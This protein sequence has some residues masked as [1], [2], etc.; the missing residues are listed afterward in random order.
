M[1]THAILFL[2][3]FTTH[4]YSQETKINEDSLQVNDSLQLLELSSKVQ[5]LTL[6]VQ[7]MKLQKIVMLN[8]LNSKGKSDSIRKIQQKSQIDSLRL[9]TK[10]VPLVIEGDTLFLLYAQKGGMRPTER[11]ES[12]QNHIISLGKKLIFN[13]DSIYA[14][15]S[16]L[17]TDIMSQD[18]II[19]SITDQDAL[20]QNCT[21]EELVN[22]YI[23]IISQCITQLHAQYGLQKKMINILLVIA[24][25]VGLIF[26]IY[27]TLKIFRILR[28]Y[29][30]KYTRKRLKP[31]AIKDYELLNIRKLEYILAG[32]VSI[33]KYMIILVEVILALSMLF[34]IFPETEDYAYLLLSY[35]WNPT[36]EI[37]LSCIRFIPDLFKIVLI[38]ILF[39]YVIKGIRY[40]AG[41]IANE[42]LK[43]TG[44]YPDWAIPTYSILRFMLY[45]FMLVMIWPLL[46]NSGSPVFQGVSVFLGL[47]IS[48]GSTSVIGNLM[49][50]FVITYMRPFRIGDQIKLND[51]VGK[52]I[53]K[54]PF[55][56]RIETP[57]KE[58]ITIPNSFVLSSHTINYSTS[59]RKSGVII[60]SDITVGYD[61]D[62]VKVEELL[63]K[64]A[65]NTKG[66]L[67]HPQPFVLI[68]TLPDFYC[69]YQ[70]NAYTKEDQTLPRMYSTLH[71]NIIDILNEAGIE[72]TSPHFYAQRDGNETT[73]PEKYKE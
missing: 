63:T 32:V 26:V 52:V 65:I 2:L 48:L 31:I 36:K 64:A 3:L 71:K 58:I 21:R 22:E 55:V 12:A 23:P 67:K 29:T 38:Y 68:K 17:F 66:V 25:V 11:A 61:V 62:R 33:F 4:I 35:I 57:K 56:I 16:E 9:V 42:N 39:K 51:T 49:A 60:Y 70:I 34:S 41:E 40:I 27:L 1:K 15:E 19:I 6:M 37:G 5:E 44:F 20:W 59:A 28:F 10:G 53:E 18:K 73:I 13:P 14:F 50:S 69:S 30:R 46:P 54:S 43:I 7:E 45:C 72:I 47:I 8:E 24:V